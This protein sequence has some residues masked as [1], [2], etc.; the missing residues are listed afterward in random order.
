MSAIA[1]WALLLSG[2][3]LGACLPVTL[4]ALLAWLR[5]TLFRPTLLK[6]D[7][8]P[9]RAI[10]AVAPDDHPVTPTLPARHPAQ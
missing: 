2:V 7:P 10:G 9:A 3:V 4:R 5:R 1:A 6:L 8:P